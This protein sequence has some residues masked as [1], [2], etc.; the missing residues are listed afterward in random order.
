MSD[1]K[2]A[3]QVAPAPGP[4]AADPFAVDSQTIEQKLCT[5]WSTYVLFVYVFLCSCV[6]LVYIC[7]SIAYLCG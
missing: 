6:Y 4:V 3:Q 7:V 5:E 1:T 2:I